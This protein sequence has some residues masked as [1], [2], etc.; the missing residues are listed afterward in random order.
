MPLPPLPLP[1]PFFAQR[2][3]GSGVGG[4]GG[5]AGE[6]VEAEFEAEDALW[7]VLKWEGLAPLA[8]Y[9]SAQ[10][11]SG[12]G[13]GS[14]FGGLGGGGGLRDRLRMLRWVGAGS[15]QERAGAGVGAE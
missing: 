7:V 13:L 1:L 6:G 3:R 14:L 12:I 4:G 11:T 9:P 15:G 8:L 10:Q 2:G 5:A